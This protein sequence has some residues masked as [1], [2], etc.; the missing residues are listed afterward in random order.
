MRESIICFHYFIE[1]LILYKL[2]N[3]FLEIYSNIVF[4]IRIPEKSTEMFV[5]NEKLQNY[6][7][8]QSSLEIRKLVVYGSNCNYLFMQALVTLQF[9]YSCTVR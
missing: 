4:S 3:R 7:R 2:I 5:N 8:L 6:I 1:F 9:S